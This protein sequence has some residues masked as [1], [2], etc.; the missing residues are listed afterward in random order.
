MLNLRT[1]CIQNPVELQLD[2]LDQMAGNLD[3]PYISGVV[4]RT[5]VIVLHQAGGIEVGDERRR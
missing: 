2:V 4:L 5:D 1:S 3:V